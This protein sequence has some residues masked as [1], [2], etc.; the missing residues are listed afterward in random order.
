MTDLVPVT[1]TI[2]ETQEHLEAFL[3]TA[4]LRGRLLTD[5]GLIAPV[6]LESGKFRVQVRMLMPPERVT[7][8]ARMAR[9]SARHDVLSAMLKALVFGLAVTLLIG[10]SLVMI[11]YALYSYF[12]SALVMGAAAAVALAGL[13]LL[14]RTSAHRSHDGWGFHWTKCK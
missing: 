13:A 7:R 1:K 5:P 14:S 8:K 12:G 2:V 4:H 9:W 10:G 6:R 11:G 3:R